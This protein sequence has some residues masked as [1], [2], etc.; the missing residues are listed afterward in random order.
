MSPSTGPRWRELGAA[1][2]LAAACAGLVRIFF[3]T[4]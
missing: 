1:I 3:F 4:H 2:V